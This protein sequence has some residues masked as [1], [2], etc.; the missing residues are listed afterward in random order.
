M[1]STPSWLELVAE[2]KRKGIRFGDCS[3]KIPVSS[4]WPTRSKKPSKPSSPTCE[5][6]TKPTEP[7][8]RRVFARLSIT[9]QR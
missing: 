6:G 8:S 1:S 2:Y 9:S 5:S 4:T 3:E 7:R